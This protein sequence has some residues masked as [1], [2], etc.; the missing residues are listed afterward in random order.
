MGWA[1]WVVRQPCR[2]RQGGQVRQLCRQRQGG[3][4]SSHGDRD[5]V[6]MLGS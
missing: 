3:Q 4:D 6:G 5:G 1:G 2:Q